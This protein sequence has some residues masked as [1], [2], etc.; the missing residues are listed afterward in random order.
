MTFF[1]SEYKVPDVTYPDFDNFEVK[2]ETDEWQKLFYFTLEECKLQD[3]QETVKII[4][5]QTQ[6]TN[7]TV[8][9]SVQNFNM[10]VMNS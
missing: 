8:I 5:F 9:F 7:R 4:W 6:N 10:I 2:N 3:F 1:F